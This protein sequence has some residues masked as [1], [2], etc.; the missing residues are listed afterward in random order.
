ML[1]PKSLI[2]KTVQGIE[3]GEDGESVERI[4]FT[5]GAEV[6]LA[7]SAGGEVYLNLPDKD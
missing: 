2:G 7:G 3:I 6:C 5:D 1:D 4:T